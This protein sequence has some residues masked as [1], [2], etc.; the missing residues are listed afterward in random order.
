MK[1]ILFHT[2]VELSKALNKEGILWAVGASVVLNHYGLIDKPND[3]DILVHIK[4]IEKVDM[5]LKRLG[6]KKLRKKTDTYAT[7][8]FYEYVMEDVDIDVMAGFIIKHNNGEYQYCFDDKSITA[9]KNIQGECIP[10]TSLEDWYVIYQLIPGR[11]YK[12][13]IIENYLLKNGLN[14][15][16]LVNRALEGNLPEEVRSRTEKLLYNIDK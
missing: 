16:N 10:L 4:D 8:Y 3:I 2:L 7:K 1:K 9:I 13:G 14:N 15:I 6:R 5:I 11:E 12:V